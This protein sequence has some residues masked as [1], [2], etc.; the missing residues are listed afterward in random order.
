MR[1][2]TARKPARSTRLR[3]GLGVQLRAMKVSRR[4]AKSVTF[5]V[6]IFNEI[7]AFIEY[8]RSPEANPLDMAEFKL[9]HRVQGILN[10]PEQR[11]A[12]LTTK[13]NCGD[14]W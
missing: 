9:Y 3:S 6:A 11:A 10:D 8:G 12:V 4:I 1:F 5:F 14:G 2:A 13:R 7:C